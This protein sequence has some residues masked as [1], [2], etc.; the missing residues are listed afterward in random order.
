MNR[1]KIVLV[2]VVLLH[3]SL[4][5]SATDPVIV[6][7]SSVSIGHDADFLRGVVA[8]PSVA[9]SGSLKLVNND[10][11]LKGSKDFMFTDGK[12]SF[13]LDA[14]AIANEKKAAASG[15]III[16][17]VSGTP[18]IFPENPNYQ[19]YGHANYWPL[20]DV[21]TPLENWQT[22]FVQWAKAWDFEIGGKNYHTIWIGS[23]EPSHTLGVPLD[24]TASFQDE[25]LI[26][27]ID[28]W[29]PIAKGLRASGAKVGGIQL[30]AGAKGYYQKAVDLLKQKEV[31]LDFLTFQ[32][33]TLGSPK[34]LDEAVSALK[35]YREKYPHAS[36]LID[37]GLWFK[38]IQMESGEKGKEDKK[39]GIK[40]TSNDG[41]NTSDGAIWF[42]RAEKQVQEQSEFVSG[43]CI[44]KPGDSE[45]MTWTILKW[46]EAAPQ[47]RQQL[48]GMPKGIDGFYLSNNTNGSI[49]LWNNGSDEQQFSIDLTKASSSNKLEM[50]VLFGNETEVT[51][52]SKNI[53]LSGKNIKNLK[54]APHQFILVSF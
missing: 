3:V 31:E 40:L 13:V 5:I 36:I 42:L 19:A 12:F 4:F 17:Q 20:P 6:A 23:Q 41:N 54:L 11:T 2:S 27:F 22:L 44:G 46:L 48:S 30:P 25:N 34:A 39:Q 1:F 15:M 53:S 47:G 28:Y 52:M 38:N 35:S 9:L 7:N 16:N 10:I 45:D 51:D 37:R 8:D 49:A 33:Y 50:K 29:K 18:A 26:R 14:I 24:S 43:Y 21:G 32:I